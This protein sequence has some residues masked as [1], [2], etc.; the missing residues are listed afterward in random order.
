MLD[1]ES[2]MEADN[3]FLKDDLGIKL[4]AH[5]KVKLL[6][7]R[8]LKEAMDGGDDV[9]VEAVAFDVPPNE[10]PRSPQRKG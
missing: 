6:K 9:V 1:G 4:G 2:L 8:K 7:I 5:R 3:D 10:Q